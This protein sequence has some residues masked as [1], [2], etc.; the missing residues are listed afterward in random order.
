MK[1]YNRIHPPWRV[2]KN[3]EKELLKTY[4]LGQSVAHYTSLCEDWALRGF[5]S[6]K[7]TTLSPLEKSKN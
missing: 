4:N 6:A 5:L 1:N 2:K 7:N 3:F